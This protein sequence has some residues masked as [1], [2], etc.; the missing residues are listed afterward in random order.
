MDYRK[1]SEFY[2]MYYKGKIHITEL[3]RVARNLKYKGK[4]EKSGHIV[5]IY[6]ESDF[7]NAV[8]KHESGKRH[9]WKKYR[10]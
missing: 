2:E 3:Y 8:Q 7:I 10:T 4:K 1:V 5:K 9:K 6:L